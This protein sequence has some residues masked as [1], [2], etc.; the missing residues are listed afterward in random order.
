MPGKKL[1]EPG[2]ADRCAESLHDIEVG[3]AVA[4]NHEW[5]VIGNRDV[6]ADQHA[7]PE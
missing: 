4:F 2:I 3:A 5:S 7:I 1:T 6:P